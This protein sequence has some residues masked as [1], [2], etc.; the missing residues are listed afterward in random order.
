MLLHRNLHRTR[1]LFN[2]DEI[3]DVL[4]CHRTATIQ[5]EEWFQFPMAGI[6]DEREPSLGNLLVSRLKLG[7]RAFHGGAPKVCG[8]G[9]ANKR[10]L[11]QLVLDG[12]N[13]RVRGSLHDVGH[14]AVSEQG[15]GGDFSARGARMLVGIELLQS[16]TQLFEQCPAIGGVLPFCKA[17]PGYVESRI[18]RDQI[19]QESLAG[20]PIRKQAPQVVGIWSQQQVGGDAFVVNLAKPAIE[21][22][23]VLKIRLIRRAKLIRST[24]K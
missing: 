18:A 14:P 9:D 7:I 23:E 20:L 3:L 5:V 24:E 16:Q 8:I 12:T 15:S 13:L 11:V 1:R 10:D 17:L 22:V 19:F 21:L 6:A 4:Q 2:I